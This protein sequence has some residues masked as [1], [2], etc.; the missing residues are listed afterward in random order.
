[1]NEPIPRLPDGYVLSP[2]YPNPFNAQ[3]QIRFTLPKAGHISLCIYDLIGQRVATLL[4][5]W[6]GAGEHSAIW[7]A[8]EAPSGLYFYQ[9][10][11]NGISE[12]RKT[13]LLR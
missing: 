2:N 6:Q 4:A 13:I 11:L 7:D 12:T 3:T 10:S 9:L 1:M 8:Q 5:G